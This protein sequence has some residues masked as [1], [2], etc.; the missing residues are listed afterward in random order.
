[1]DAEDHEAEVAVKLE[2]AKDADVV[3]KAFVAKDALVDAEAQLELVVVNEL[4]ANEPDI[5]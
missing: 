3:D 5:A 4:E 2:E 1:M